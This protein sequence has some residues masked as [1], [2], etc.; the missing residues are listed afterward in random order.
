MDFL[1][2]RLVIKKDLITTLGTDNFLI[3]I[4][5]LPFF[6]GGFAMIQTPQYYRAIRVV[7]FKTY[8]YFF[9][10]FRNKVEPTLLPTMRVHD[11]NPWCF[12]RCLLPRK[13]HLYPA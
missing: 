8:Q 4:F 10:D 5:I 7:I 1:L 13:S 11:P 12:L 6:R 9:V 3:I 2:A